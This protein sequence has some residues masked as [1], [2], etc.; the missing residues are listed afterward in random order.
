MDIFDWYQHVKWSSKHPWPANQAT[1]ANLQVHE[2]C[3]NREMTRRD[4]HMGCF[5]TGAG[6]K[7]AFPIPECDRLWGNASNDFKFDCRADESTASHPRLVLWRNV[8]EMSSLAWGFSTAEWRDLTVKVEL[9]IE[10]S[11]RMRSHEYEVMSHDTEYNYT[12]LFPHIAA[13]GWLKQDPTTPRTFEDFSSAAY[14]VVFCGFRGGSFVFHSEVEY[15][16]GDI[17]WTLTSWHFGISTTFSK[18]LWWH[19][20]LRCSGMPR[21]AHFDRRARHA[22]IEPKSM[23]T[24][25]WLWLWLLLQCRSFSW[26][27]CASLQLRL[28]RKR[29]MLKRGD[30]R[31]GNYL[32]IWPSGVLKSL[33]IMRHHPISISILHISPLMF[34]F[35]CCQ[36]SPQLCHFPL[37]ISHRILCADEVVSHAAPWKRGAKFQE[38]ALWVAQ[39]RQMKRRDGGS[40]T[41]HQVH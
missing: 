7:P 16:V 24:R 26:E 20:I 12:N 25:W 23:E 1:T 15:M 22:G 18:G 39:G 11:R 37:Q 9:D 10:R 34:I 19:L 28:N 33:V 13:R 14:S 27:V 40:W 3:W 36:L 4:G 35:S 31:G 21:L 8:W 6:A 30:T 2:A 41:I 5:I 32:R 38:V 17:T 29:V